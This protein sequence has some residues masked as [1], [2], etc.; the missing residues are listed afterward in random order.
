M[1]PKIRKPIKAFDFDKIP[2]QRKI[3]LQP[4]VEYIQIKLVA[5][6]RINLTFVCTHNSR[7]SHLTQVW[8]KLAGMYYRLRKVNTYSGGTEATAVYA[9]IL[10]TLTNQGFEYVSISSEKNA[11]FAL[12]FDESSP[13]IILFSKMVD[14]FI[15]PTKNFAAVMCCNDAD[16]NCP[17]VDGSDARFAVPYVDPKRSDNTNEKVKVYLE[18]SLEIGREMFYVFSQIER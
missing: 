6:E 2:T 7:R 1:Y 4:L 15:N 9:Q 10:W 17:V 16:K 13:P 11:V 3:I 18:K 12:R 5:N 14:N 8:A